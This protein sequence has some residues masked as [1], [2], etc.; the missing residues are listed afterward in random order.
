MKR[1]KAWLA[2]NENNLQTSLKKEI[3]KELFDF[4]KTSKSFQSPKEMF[5]GVTGVLDAFDIELVAEDGQKFKGNV[6]N[7]K[8]SKEIDIAP[9]SSINDRSEYIPYPN[10]KLTIGWVVTNDEVN[11]KDAY[12]K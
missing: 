2:E 9:K 8:G 11:I 6:I 1:F 7:S 10:T 3:N 5:I 12:L 4:V